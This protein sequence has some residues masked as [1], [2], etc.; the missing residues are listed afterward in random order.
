MSIDLSTVSL[1][2]LVAPNERQIASVNHSDKVSHVLH[3]RRIYMTRPGPLAR[4]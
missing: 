3:V 1:K 4:G 2:S